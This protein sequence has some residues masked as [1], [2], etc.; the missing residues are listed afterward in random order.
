MDQKS[1]NSDA[2]QLRKNIQHLLHAVGD[3]AFC[4][5]CQAPIYWVKHKNGKKAPYNAEG[6]NHFADCPKAGDFKR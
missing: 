3:S 6:L 2:D 5:G 4:R 1:L